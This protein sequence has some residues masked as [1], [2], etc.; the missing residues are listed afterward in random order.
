MTQE[1]NEREK[2]E[3]VLRWL[4]DESGRDEQIVE[5]FTDCHDDDDDVSKDQNKPNNQA[6]LVKDVN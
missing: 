5:G 2:A 3:N 6:P 4:T 1:T